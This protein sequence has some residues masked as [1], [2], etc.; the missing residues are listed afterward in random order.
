MRWLLE[1]LGLDA[2]LTGDLLEECS[3]GRSR[4]WYWRQVSIAIWTG[5]W[6]AIFNHKVLALRAVVMGCAV[7]SVWNF[8]WLRFLH[9]GF[10][11]TPVMRFEPVACLLIILASQSV[12]GWVV[13]RTHRACSIAMVM[14]FA[15]WLTA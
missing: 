1:R 12:T 10:P 6:G 4:I 14:V 3:R 13:A 8:L 7:N 9:I 11:V 5:I 2:A 15:I